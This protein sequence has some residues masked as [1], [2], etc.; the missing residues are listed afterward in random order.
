M[1]RGSRA[2]HNQHSA[3][4][5]RAEGKEVRGQ[6]GRPTTEDSRELA[7]LFFLVGEF[8]YRKENGGDPERQKIVDP[9]VDY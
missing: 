2:G 7:E 5:K 4:E 6:H 3:A 9:P 8:V 1:D